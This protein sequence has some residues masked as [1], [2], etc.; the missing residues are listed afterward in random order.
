MRKNVEYERETFRLK[1]E[2]LSSNIWLTTQN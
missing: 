1:V 2:L